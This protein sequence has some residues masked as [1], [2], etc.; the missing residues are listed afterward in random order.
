MLGRRV[1]YRSKSK[2]PLWEARSVSIP[3]SAHLH[4]SL[5][6]SRNLFVSTHTSYAHHPPALPLLYPGRM[7]NEILLPSAYRNP[8]Q[9]STFQVRPMFRRQLQHCCESPW[10]LRQARRVRDL[11]LSRLLHRSGRKG[12][13]Q[14]ARELR[15]SRMQRA[16][17]SKWPV[18]PAFQYQRQRQH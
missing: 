11:L 7:L 2:G 8:L 4:P 14:Q 5:P 13:L 17:K 10:S 15:Q 12:P 18:Q 3:P 1:C 6:P 9:F 16:G